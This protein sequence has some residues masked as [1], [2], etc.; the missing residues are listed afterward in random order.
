MLH[1]N[2]RV[3]QNWA[4][5]AAWEDMALSKS[6]SFT[7]VMKFEVIWANSEEIRAHLAAPFWREEQAD[8]NG[9]RNQ[10]DH[11]G[12][13]CNSSTETA[14]SRHSP[15]LTHL[16]LSWKLSR[17]QTVLNLREHSSQYQTNNKIKDKKLGSANGDRVERRGH[18]DAAEDLVWEVI[19]VECFEVVK[20]R[21]E[22]RDACL[23]DYSL[24]VCLI[25]LLLVFK[26]GY[27]NEMIRE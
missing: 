20:N 21:G 22:D 8:T 12:V 27:Q 19:R 25:G 3:K 18:E 5:R 23:F 11:L 14:V 4:S 6:T 1:L 9:V 17:A 16:S 13:Y 26:G 15:E 7:C 10:R 2:Q 24:L